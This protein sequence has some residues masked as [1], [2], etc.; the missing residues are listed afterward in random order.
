MSDVD[1]TAGLLRHEYAHGLEER[2]SVEVMAEFREAL[3]RNDTGNLNL[4]GI[5]ELGL[6]SYSALKDDEAF[7][8][9]IAIRTSPQWEERKDTF[10][11]FVRKWGDRMMGDLLQ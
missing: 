11:E 3:P 1:G 7:A 8:E 10:P 5:R 6:T 2:V 4:P 9:L